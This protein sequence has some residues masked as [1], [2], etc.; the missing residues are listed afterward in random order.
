MNQSPISA[1]PVFFSAAILR[2]LAG[3]FFA[4]ALSLPAAA[5][6]APDSGTVIFTF[7]FPNSSPE[8]YSITVEKNGHAHY[9]S[10]AKVSDESDDRETYQTDVELLDA[11]RVRIFDLAAQAH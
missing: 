2:L 10:V 6:D 7:E 1:K 4:L 9:E 5:A 8:R 11:T 3:I